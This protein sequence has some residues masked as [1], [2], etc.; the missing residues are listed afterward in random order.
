MENTSKQWIEIKISCALHVSVESMVVST[1]MCNTFDIISLPNITQRVIKH[2]GNSFETRIKQNV[3]P[4]FFLI[5]I[6]F[7]G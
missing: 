4:L 7:Q 2:K 5:L 1:K 6:K 3:K